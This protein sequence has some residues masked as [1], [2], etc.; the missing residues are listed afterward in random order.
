[1][2]EALDR[3]GLGARV[4]EIEPRL[5]DAI[6]LRPRKARAADLAPG[7]SR[8]GGA[9]DL[10]G[11]LARVAEPGW[12]AIFV[13]Q[14]DLAAVAPWD[15]HHALPDA[16]LLS[17]FALRQGDETV[18]ARVIYT[19]S[20]ERLTADR[21]D[22]KDKVLGVEFEARVLAPPYNSL[23]YPVSDRA[24]V[25]FYDALRELESGP[26]R[27]HGSVLLGYDRGDERA[28]RPDEALLLRV[29]SEDGVQFGFPAMVALYYVVAGQA[30]KARTFDT[31]RAVLGPN[32]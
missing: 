2:L 6:G 1:V 3:A 32:V 10:P 8:F 12:D 9:P 19:A 11:G 13:G 22:T 18:R 17:F 24:Y 15:L 4:A 27:L 20:T 7:T 31:V 25:T 29:D 28:L 21:P 14:L 23:G 26:E 5:R 30:L 16:G